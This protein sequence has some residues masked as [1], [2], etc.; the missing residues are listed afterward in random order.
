MTQLERNVVAIVKSVIEFHERFDLP[1][2]DY[3]YFQLNDKDW[4]AATLLSHFQSRLGLLV[5]EVG[6]VAK[7][8]NHGDIEASVKEVVD[9]LYIVI[10]MLYD[11]GDQRIESPIDEIINKNGDKTLKTHEIHP[12]TGKIVR[13]ERSDEEA[14]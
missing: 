14:L 9:V 1:P 3:T 7:A 12:V 6:E 13:R 5:E 8:L 2:I 10:G 4:E 11:I